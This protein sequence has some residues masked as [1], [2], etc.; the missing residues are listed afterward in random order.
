MSKHSQYLGQRVFL[1]KAVA[2]ISS[3]VSKIHILDWIDSLRKGS[4]EAWLLHETHQPT[5]CPQKCTDDPQIHGN[6]L[7][8]GGIS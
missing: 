6:S 7:S 5:N 8:F 4:F 2:L 3:F 1:V